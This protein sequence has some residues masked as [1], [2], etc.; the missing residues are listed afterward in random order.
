LTPPLTVKGRA[1]EQFT[2]KRGAR[3]RLSLKPPGGDIFIAKQK[4]RKIF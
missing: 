1:A 3:A 4:I 2:R